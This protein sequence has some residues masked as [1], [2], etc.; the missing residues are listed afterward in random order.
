M[1]STHHGSTL[2]PPKYLAWWKLACMLCSRCLPPS[3]RSAPSSKLSP[4]YVP[5]SPV[6]RAERCKP[7]PVA[8][9][10]TLGFSRPL[11][12]SLLLLASALSGNIIP[13]YK[14]SAWVPAKAGTH[15]SGR[16][17]QHFEL[18]DSMLGRVKK[19]TTHNHSL[20]V[21]YVR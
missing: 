2:P 20:R 11:T 21:Q 19:V 17:G 7:C 15:A 6:S 13:G 1:N 5:V 8:L 16:A 18:F 14:G 4:L 9:V 3:P 10:P 12:P